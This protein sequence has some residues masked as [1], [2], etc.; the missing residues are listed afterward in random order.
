VEAVLGVLNRT[1][2]AKELW[3][4]YRADRLHE[5]IE[6]WVEEQGIAVSHPPPWK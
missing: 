3:Y 6:D 2:E 5:T 1:P 4:L